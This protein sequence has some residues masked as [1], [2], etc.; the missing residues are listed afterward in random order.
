MTGDA[1]LDEIERGRRGAEDA[2][3]RDVPA[4]VL[5]V[6]VTGALVEGDEV[7]CVAM[8]THAREEPRVRDAFPECARDAE[9]HCGERDLVVVRREEGK[10]RPGF[11][12]S[13]GF[14]AGI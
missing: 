9:I 3:E 13:S 12:S 14:F 5:E 2:R 4:R 7:V 10:R 1:T 8:E 11:Q 6:H